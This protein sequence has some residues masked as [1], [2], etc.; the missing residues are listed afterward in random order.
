MM[1]V[2][3]QIASAQGRRD[4]VPNKE[5]AKALAA[6]ENT[7]GI[8]E[9]VDNLHNEDP[10][11]ISDCIK[12]LYEVGYINPSLIAEYWQAFLYLLDNKHN[13]L[14]WGGMTALSTIAPLKAD[15]LFPHT[16]KLKQA[17]MKGSVI[18]KDGGI[19]TLSL[20]GSVSVEYR[21]EVLPFLLDFLAHCRPKQVPRYAEDTFQAVDLQNRDAF[22]QVLKKRLPD[23]TE[24]QVKRVNKVITKAHKLDSSS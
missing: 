3:D 1:S 21:R 24:R 15:V 11:I 19:R 23:L 5:L 10:K 7:A 12:V 17:I 9:I 8:K 14:V 18:T 13:R 4:D 22:I 6:E 16:E 20:I 2:V